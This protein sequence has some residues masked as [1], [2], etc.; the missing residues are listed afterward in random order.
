MSGRPGTPSVSFELGVGGGEVCSSARTG[1]GLW[2][3]ACWAWAHSCS[4]RSE[5]GLWGA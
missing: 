4:Y 5:A 2:A 1:H 3:V